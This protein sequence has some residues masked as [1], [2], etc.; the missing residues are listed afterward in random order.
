MT[1]NVWR[2][3]WRID[4]RNEETMT[5][6]SRRLS[7][8]CIEVHTVTLSC[9]HTLVKK[10]KAP[11]TK[12]HCERCARGEAPVELTKP[13]G[14]YDHRKKTAATAVVDALLQNEREKV[15]QLEELEAP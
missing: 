9:G 3:V 2:K 6:S 10:H 7:Y 11:A 1:T 12:A 4:T 15:A 14:R 13:A 5:A 8:R